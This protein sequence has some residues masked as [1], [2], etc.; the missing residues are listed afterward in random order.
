MYTARDNERADGVVLPWP[1]QQIAGQPC[2][3]PLTLAPSLCSAAVQE[4]AM[5]HTAGEDWPQGVR[6]RTL[7]D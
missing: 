2:R 1:G 4:T 5:A 6:G 7:Y 3:S